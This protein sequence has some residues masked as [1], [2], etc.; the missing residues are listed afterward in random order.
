MAKW[1]PCK[2]RDFIRKLKKL[3]FDPPEPGGQRFYMRRGTFTLALPGNTDYSVPQI[4][5]ST[6]R[7]F[8][9]I[10]DPNDLNVLNKINRKKQINPRQTRQTK[11]SIFAPFPLPVR[12]QFHSNVPQS[13][14]DV[15]RHVLPHRFLFLK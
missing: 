15:N 13:H 14:R 1:A 9:D 6:N 4:D 11:L 12:M 5:A 7:R 3:G 10:T 8:N 2:R